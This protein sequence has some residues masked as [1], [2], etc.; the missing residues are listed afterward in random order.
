MVTKILL[1]SGSDGYL[2]LHEKGTSIHFPYL[3]RQVPTSWHTSNGNFPTKDSNEFN[4]KQFDYSNRKKYLVTP[5]VV[6]YDKKSD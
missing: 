1:Y 4:I 3:T 2:M 5:D 6:E